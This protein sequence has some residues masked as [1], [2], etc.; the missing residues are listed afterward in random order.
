MPIASWQWAHVAVT[1][2]A[3]T[4][5]S[6]SRGP[7]MRCSPWQ[8]VQ[9]GD[10]LTPRASAVPWTLAPYSLACCAWQR[11]QV[12]RMFALWMEAAGSIGLRRGWLS[13]QYFRVAVP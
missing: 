5:E 8:S 1:P 11:P 3:A 13:W 9:V 7:R 6:T 2:A 12:T 10:D 4:G